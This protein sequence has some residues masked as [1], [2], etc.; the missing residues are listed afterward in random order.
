[1]RM[2]PAATATT[3]GPSPRQPIPE[4]PCACAASGASCARCA[5]ANPALQRKAGGTLPARADIP[6][7]VRHGLAS[8]GRPLDAA[9]RAPLERSFGADFSHVRVHSGDAAAESAQALR[10]RAYTVGHHIV[11]GPGGHDR[12]LLAHE[13]AHVVQQS[14]REGGGGAAP[15]ALE[16]EADRAAQAASHGAPFDVR[17]RTGPDVQRKEDEGMFGVVKQKVIDAVLS[18]LGLNGTGVKLVTAGVSGAIEG[19]GHQWTEGGTGEK[20]GQKAM[21]F[22]V[23]DIPAFLS[24]YVQGVIKGVVSPIT[25]LFSIAVLMEQGHDFAWKIAQSALSGKGELEAELNSLLASLQGLAAPI[26]TALKGMK[27]KPLETLK[28]LVAFATSQGTMIA[29]LEEMA[30]GAGRSGGQAIAKSL[31]DP[32]E[33]PADKKPGPA[34]SPWKQPMQWAN[35]KL[36]QAG[37]ALLSGAWGKVGDKVGYALGFAVVQVV[38]LVFSDGIGNLITSIGKG[39][40]GLAKAGSLLGKTLEGIG[41][42]VQA[43]GAG[44]RVV[45][46]AVA[47]MITLLAKPML[48]ILEPLMKPFGQAM[49]RLGRFLRKLLGIAE[50]DAAH[51][52]TTAV[53]KAEGTLAEHAVAPHAPAPH[54]PAPQAPPKPA[55]EPKPKP[56]TGPA[57]ERGKILAEKPTYDGHHAR[58]RETGIEL[59]SPEPCPL[60]ENIYGDLIGKHDRLSK[61]MQAIQALRK[62]NPEEAAKRT[63]ALKKELD[64][65]TAGL[66]KEYAGFQDLAAGEGGDP[67]K[68]A[69]HR[70]GKTGSS[71]A[72]KHDPLKQDI[73]LNID[74]IE[75]V[76]AQFDIHGKPLSLDERMRRAKSLHNREFKDALTNQRTKHVG[77]DPRDAARLQHPRPLVSLKPPKGKAPGK[78]YLAVFDRPL[79]DIQ[80]FQTVHEMV[81]TKLEQSGGTLTPGQMKARLNAGMWEEIRHPT[82]PD[83]KTIADAI[84]RG[85]FGIVQAPN[86]NLV[87]RALSEQELLARGFRYTEAGWVKPAAALPT[88]PAPAPA[89]KSP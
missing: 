36:E 57:D 84:E 87:L 64:E 56:R 78:E 70:P 34:F 75:P 42:F 8:P 28:S 54:A 32:W 23:R 37:E 55:P 7:N 60:I 21:T 73:T 86:G 74:E 13:L 20:L 48:P 71:T 82:T 5:G 33:E 1:M 79:G 30:A 29:K 80:E 88:T 15:D 11:L 6:D 85:G 12:N 66:K 47:A 22:G 68:V 69:S 39:M 45:E 89:P 49:D 19:F 16:H 2:S 51:L 67:S 61:E 76:G 14:G 59:C 44:V 40:G 35:Q 50:K 83:G 62:T 24:G 31:E 65:M 18:Q 9:T 77:V 41:K 27:D 10:A 38:L 43:A 63:A 17:G 4:R 46:E 25:D 58:V 72:P 81:L 26:K 52:A 53:A 3:A